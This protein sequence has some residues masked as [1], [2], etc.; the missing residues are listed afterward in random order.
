MIKLRPYQQSAIGDIKENWKA[1]RRKVILC[2]PT[3]GGK[4][5]CFS[6]MAYETLT[7][8]KRPG[9]RVLILTDREE[10]L[11]QA[12]G[13]LTKFGIRPEHIKSGN[14]DKVNRRARCFVGMI[15]TYFNWLKEAIKDCQA[16]WLLNFDLII[17]D[18]AHKG[19]FRKV[20]QLWAEHGITPYLVGATA[21]PLSTK[22]D[23]PLSNYYDALVC[24]VQI[25]EL[26]EQGFLVP[27]V[28]YAAKVDRSK[29]KT[30]TK[31]E[32]TD[33]SQMDVF[34]GRQ[35]YGGLVE[36]YKQY[37]VVDGKPLKAI[38][39][40][41]NVEHSL[42]VC[43]A[44]NDADIRAVHV[45]GETPDDQRE[46]I[47]RDFKNGKIDVLCNVSIATTGFDEPSIRVVIVNRATTSK[48]LWLQMVGRGSRL[49]TDK[50]HFIL[51]DMGDNYK[52]LD[53]WE[54]PV[55]WEDLWCKKRK[56]SDKKDVA[57]VRECPLC[58]AL[59]LAA[60]KHCDVCGYEF[61]KPIRAEAEAVEF[62]KV[63]DGLDRLLKA[64]PSDWKTLPVADLWALAEA[65]EYKP[66]WVIHV[67]RQRCETESIFRDEI[68]EFA[69]LKGYKRGWA[70]RIEYQLTPVSYAS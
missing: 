38:C 52:E 19:N 34:G 40:N 50:D 70:I 10:L 8:K 63:S 18:E 43:Q 13:S 4:T 66:G 14:K 11:T 48:V 53:L 36:K 24:P 62:E 35:V 3:G 39:F 21:T 49:F 68:E 54:S 58:E 64:R 55:D 42:A 59:S 17:I 41:V 25:S 2:L 46:A 5:A 23:D 47:F 67:L 61:P 33:A 9:L 45:D 16:E 28:T 12:G 20:L 69:R 26:V 44:F 30:D 65:K 51:L 1:G 6:Y 32:Y 29:F 27:A 37:G 60:H 56:K 57:P 15:E 7:N 22:K 31:G